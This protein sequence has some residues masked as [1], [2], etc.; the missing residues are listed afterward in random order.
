M[1]INSI[2][3]I[4]AIS[5]STNCDIS[6]FYTSGNCEIS[7]DPITISNKVNDYFLN[8]AKNASNKISHFLKHFFRI[9]NK[10]K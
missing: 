9:F 2:N 8:V 4:I 6:S 1:A 10:Q 5:K 7:S 3:S